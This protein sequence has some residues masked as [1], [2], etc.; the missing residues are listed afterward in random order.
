VPGEA[1]EIV[2]GVRQLVFQRIL[3]ALGVAAPG[4]VLR[5]TLRSWLS[6]T[7]TAGLDWLERRDMPRATLESMLVAQMVALLQVAGRYDPDVACL[8]GRDGPR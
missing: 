3:E 4:P 7:E 2:D 8:I 6:G 1:G 5:L